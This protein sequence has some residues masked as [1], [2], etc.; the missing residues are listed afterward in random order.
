MSIINGYGH[1]V[2]KLIS[3]DSDIETEV[4]VTLPLTNSGGLIES[5]EVKKISHELI[6]LNPEAP[7]IIN[8]QRILGYM[9]TFTLNYNRWI[10]GEALYDS[11][12]KIFEAAKAGWKIVLQPRD[13]APWREFEV[14]LANETLE[15]GINKGGRFARTHRLPVL[16]F[17]SARL[18][19]ELKWFPPQYESPG[20]GTGLPLEG[21]EEA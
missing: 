8:A 1:P 20:G 4:T 15:L 14:I 12:K 3:V 19:P 17:R 18:E 13:D 21:S 10:A 9:I 5:Y 2:I 6:S 7:D 11:F 16:V